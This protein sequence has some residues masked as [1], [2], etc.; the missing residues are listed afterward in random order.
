M[1]D[2]PDKVFSVLEEESPG[3][4]RDWLG[5]PK[6]I[7]YLVSHAVEHAGRHVGHMELTRQLWDQ[8]SKR[9]R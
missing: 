2:F 5:K 9:G 4:E 1:D 7:S 3:V 6:P 8:R